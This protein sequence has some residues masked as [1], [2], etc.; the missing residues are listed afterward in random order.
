M[1]QLRVSVSDLE[2]FR[3]WR[4]SEDDS[5][6]ELLK[7]LRREEPPTPAMKA[8]SAF[9]AAL[10]HC[11]A[12]VLGDFDQDGF[13]FEWA[14]DAELE[15]PAI[16]ELKAE[17]RIH[18][19][20]LDLTL[21]GKV[22]ALHGM[23]VIDFK[24]TS[25]FDAERYIRTYQ[26]RAYTSMFRA[27]TFRWNVFEMKPKSERVYLISAVHRLEQHRYS[28]MEADVLEKLVDY[29]AFAKAHLPEMFTHAS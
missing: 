2:A 7:R 19:Q 12:D 16:R 29:V 9:H 6:E 14:C 21:V 24:T 26:W 3:E 10:E 18:T 22:D 1:S 5:L 28:G 13:R 20:G 23:T 25:Q 8:G 27:D 11:D 4:E 15:L 17:E